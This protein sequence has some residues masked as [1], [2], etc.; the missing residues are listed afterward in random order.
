CSKVMDVDRLPVGNRSTRGRVAINDEALTHSICHGNRAKVRNKSQKITIDAK[1]RSIFS[2]TEPGSS[3]GNRI[4]HGLN[5]DWRACDHS[6]NV[7][8]RCLRSSDSS[9]SRLSSLTSWL[10]FALSCFRERGCGP[11]PCG[12]DGGF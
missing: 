1:N 7:A 3:F 2:V 9:R 10:S 12:P 11:C 8:G 4:K 6:Q 5:V